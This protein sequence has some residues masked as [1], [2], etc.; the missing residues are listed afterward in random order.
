MQATYI[1]QL[2]KLKTNSLRIVEAKIV[3]SREKSRLVENG[4]KAMF[5]SLNI[6]TSIWKVQD[7]SVWVDLPLK[8]PIWLLYPENTLL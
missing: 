1:R 4:L 2:W 5:S 7:P 8:P 6:S 3:A